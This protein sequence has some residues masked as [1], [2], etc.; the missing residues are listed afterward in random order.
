MVAGLGGV[1]PDPGPRFSRSGSNQIYVFCNFSFN[2][3]VN[4][5]EIL[6]LHKRYIPFNKSSVICYV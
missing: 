6:T 4:I 2:L 3:K 5:I 1:N